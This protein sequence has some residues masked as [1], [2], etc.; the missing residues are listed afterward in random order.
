MN[1]S[2]TTGGMKVSIRSTPEANEHI[3]AFYNE[4]KENGTCKASIDM[5]FTSFNIGESG[6][7]YGIYH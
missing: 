6:D 5:D 7:T 4:D 2:G 3:Q 1:I